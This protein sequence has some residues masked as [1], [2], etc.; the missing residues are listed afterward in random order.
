MKSLRIS[1]PLSKHPVSEQAPAGIAT[2]PN[3]NATT[4]VNA[5]FMQSKYHNR[6]SLQRISLMNGL[7]HKLILNFG[8]HDLSL[9]DEVHFHHI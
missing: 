9:R 7:P 2:S 6:L 3:M 8:K 4:E 5:I 1:M